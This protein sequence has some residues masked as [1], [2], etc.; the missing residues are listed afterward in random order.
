MGRTSSPGFI[1]VLSDPDTFPSLCPG[2][3]SKNALDWSA[4]DIHELRPPASGYSSAWRG[5]STGNAARHWTT[6][7]CPLRS[8][9]PM[10]LRHLTSTLGM[11]AT[12]IASVTSLYKDR[13]T[14]FGASALGTATRWLRGCGRHHKALLADALREL[15]TTAVSVND[16]VHQSEHWLF[17]RRLV[18]P[19]DRNLRDMARHGI[20]RPGECGARNDSHRRAARAHPQGA[21]AH[22]LKT[23]W[24]GG[25]TVLIGW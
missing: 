17:D 6:P 21:F 1:C 16:L 4:E 5:R 9:H 3:R 2:A 24:T 12:D 8:C 22:V 19:G 15:A 14:R 11:S 20:C 18:L 7:R 13:A 23:I 10:L 25:Y